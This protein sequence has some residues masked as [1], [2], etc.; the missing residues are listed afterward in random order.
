MGLVTRTTER[1]LLREFVEG[2]WPAVLAYQSD[3]QYLRFY[4][5]TERT[6]EDVRRFVQRLVDAQ[7]EQPRTKFQLAIVLRADGH[8]IGNCGIRMK[9]AGAWEADLGYEIAPRCW[10]HGYAT[11]AARSMLAFGFEELRVHRVCAHC[12]AENAASARV[13][14][15]IGMRREGHLRESEWMRGRWWDTFLYGILDYEWRARATGA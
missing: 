13:L 5:W 11:E 1:L 10:G 8:L 3:Q 15:K 7:R 14:E 9:A 4:H 2:D 6:P 12:I